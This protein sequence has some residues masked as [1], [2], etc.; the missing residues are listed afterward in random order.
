M[1][2]DLSASV[3]AAV[4]PAGV[5]IT[6]YLPDM[7]E[8]AR[9]IRN[10]SF[11]DH[12]GSIETSAETWAHSL[13]SSAFRPGLSFL[14]YQGVRAARHADQPGARGLPRADRAS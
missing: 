3:P 7:A 5:A 13:A 11:R 14:A 8:H 4:I 2:R 10:E 1:V 6:G 12:W 9:L